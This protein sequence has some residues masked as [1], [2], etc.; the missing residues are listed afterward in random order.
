MRALAC[1]LLAFM[2]A[3]IPT[4]RKITY[5]LKLRRFADSYDSSIDSSDLIVRSI[6]DLLSC[7]F[8]AGFGDGFLLEGLSICSFFSE[9]REYFPNPCLSLPPITGAN[10]ILS[11]KL[12]TVFFLFIINVYV[13]I[14]E[15][16]VLSRL[17]LNICI[18]KDALFPLII[19]S[20]S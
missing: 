19:A 3:L 5:I 11:I 9:H 1:P 7:V 10:A 13:F 16:S 18:F 2:H 14:L 8:C 12:L 15:C 6:A 20:S 17:E 4:K